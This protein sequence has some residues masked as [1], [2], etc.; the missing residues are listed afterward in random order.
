MSL[1]ITGRGT[2]AGANMAN[3]V[4]ASKPGTDSATVGTSGA[5]GERVAVVCAKARIL[6]SL[7]MGRA[8]GMLS[9]MTW[10]LPP[11]RS[12]MAN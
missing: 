5:A 8:E 10:M 9:N 1:S 4:V 6:P 2:L 3:Q 11:I 12:G 7:A